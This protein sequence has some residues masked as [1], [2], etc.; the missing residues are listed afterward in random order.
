MKIV[1]MPNLSANGFARLANT[2]NNEVFVRVELAGVFSEAELVQLAAQAIALE[3][4]DF[5]NVALE[6]IARCPAAPAE[7]LH[8]LY[9]QGDDEVREA[10]CQREDLDDGLRMMCGLTDSRPS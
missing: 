8:R 3:P 6:L 4:D 10:V 7:L 9:R 5:A 1:L 2:W